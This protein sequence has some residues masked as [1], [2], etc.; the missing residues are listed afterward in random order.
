[1]A[2]DARTRPLAGP[3]AGEPEAEV[4]DGAFVGID[5][6]LEKLWHLLT[7]M[8]FALVL[9]LGL[10]VLGLIGSLVIQAPAGVLADPTAK[11][12]WLD[13]IRPRYGGWTGIMDT[14]GVF[15]IFDSIWFRLIAAGLVIST[16]ACSLH[17]IPGMWRTATKPHVGVGE[18]FF[19]HA[20]QRESVHLAA[21]PDTAL[22][23][24]RATFRKHHYRTLVEDDGAIHLYADRFRWIPFAGLMA[25]LALV[26]IV[27]GAMIGATFGFRD[28][29]FMLAEGSSAAVPTRPGL[30]VKLE[31]FQDAYYA[32]TGAPSDYASDLILYKNGTEVAHKTVRVN[33]PLRY[34]GITFYQS[35]YGPA[36]VMQVADSSGKTLVDEGVPLAWTSTDGVRRIGSFTVPSADLTVWVVGTA[37]DT[38]TVVKPGQMRVELYKTDNDATPVDSVSIDQG[39]PTQIAGLTFTFERELQFSG[40]SLAQDP[41][42]PI[43]WF[44][45]ALLLIGFVIRFTIPNRRIWGR[46]V[47]DPAGGSNLALAGVGRGDP[48]LGNEFSGLLDDIQTTTE[49]QQA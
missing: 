19:E 39:K 48:G 7:S 16:L 25:H 12:D 47:A 40:L 17:R 18:A 13:R 42:A 28:P 22:E 23:H 2:H 6:V 41:G 20:P 3:I 4:D 46:L 32:D 37:G 33:S 1:M 45:C 38:D 26:V 30:T 31:K 27:I 5:V 14:L 9:I 44:G 15:D 36:A 43:V 21:A 34:D 29:N 11:A 49:S 10:A 24:V 8:R 35:F